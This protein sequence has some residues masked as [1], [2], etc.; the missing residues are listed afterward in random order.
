MDPNLPPGLSARDLE[1][2]YGT[3]ES[4]VCTCGHRKD[5]EHDDEFP[6]ACQVDDCGCR[7]FEE[8]FKL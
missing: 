1:H 7:G 4:L 2:I 3:A 8:D 6:W 5:D